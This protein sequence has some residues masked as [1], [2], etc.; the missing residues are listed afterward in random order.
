MLVKLLHSVLMLFQHFMLFLFGITPIKF[1]IN[2]STLML[3]GLIIVCVMQLDMLNSPNI[4]THSAE[5]LVILD[6]AASF[7]T[8]DLRI[9]VFFLM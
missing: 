8:G 1:Y 3:G 9:N 7:C 2:V 5:T 4:G 6:L